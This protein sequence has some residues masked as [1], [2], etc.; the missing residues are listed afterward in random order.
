MAE[1]LNQQSHIET[2]AADWAIRLA[3]SPL[4]FAEQAEL[5]AWLAKSPQHRTAF[6]YAQSTWLQ[7]DLLKADPGPLRADMDF[8]FPAEA[9]PI[10]VAAKP[11]RWRMAGTTTV[12]LLMVG[13]VSS[14]WFGNPVTALRADYR[15]GVGEMKTVALDDGSR[16]NLGP[17]T[18]IAVHFTGKERRVEVLAG[19]ASFSAVSRNLAG[20]RS[21]VVEAANGEAKALGT[22][23]V[24]DH[25]PR[26][27]RV[28]VLEHNVDVSATSAAGIYAHA[29]VSPGKQLSYDDRGLASVSDAM[30]GEADAW[31]RGKLML[32]DMPLRNVVAQLNRYR[33]G[34]IIV[35][36]DRLANERVSG[37]FHTN[38]IDGAIETIAREVGA[39]TVRLGPVATIIR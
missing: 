11:R 30:A 12:S 28:T 24:V 2:V 6:D 3:G 32:V 16:V 34:K 19:V 36:N 15:T 20:G 5:D 33:H 8:A 38:D 29:V 25:A 22:R 26:S 39:S 9:L 23:F 21:F 27:V 13:L 18:A 7:L 10:P 4:T 31:Q 37:V 1:D 14:F 35:L 17:D